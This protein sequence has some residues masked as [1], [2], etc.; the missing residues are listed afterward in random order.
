MYHK[1]GPLKPEPNENNQCAFKDSEST[2]TQWPIL[3]TGPNGGR[4]QYKSDTVQ[5]LK[6]VQLKAV[7]WDN[8]KCAFKNLDL[9]F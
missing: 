8:G 1:I 9:Y 6:A 4:M 5:M 3:W 2:C 7:H